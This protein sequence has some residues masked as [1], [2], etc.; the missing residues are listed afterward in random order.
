MSTAPYLSVIT[1]V[2]QAQGYI[3]AFYSKM[4]QSIKKITDDY[5]IIFVNDGSPDLSL[6]KLKA[7]Q[8]NDPRVVIADLSRNFGQ[9][10]A[11]W[12]GLKLSRGEFVFIIDCDME[13]SPDY[14]AEF[15][16]VQKTQAADIVFAAQKKRKRA[17]HHRFTGNVFYWIIAKCTSYPVIPNVLMM[18]LMTRQYVDT[19]L[20]FREYDPRLTIL[21]YNVG[22]KSVCVPIEKQFK[23]AS[24]YTFDKKVEEAWAYL[25]GI[26]N[27]PLLYIAY[28]GALLLAFF[29][30]AALG[31]G[32]FGSNRLTGWLIVML[33]VSTGLVLTAI[34]TV[35]MYLGRV[36]Q[37]VRNPPFP[38][39]QK[40]YGG[41]A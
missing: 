7:I 5:E 16:Q 9:H 29:I 3:D 28:L 4:L 27:R 33:G 11:L 26:S 1:S 15:H 2:Y 19:L 24:S 41:K 40:L 37:E 21:A 6:E 12:A 32:M 35:G 23:G 31:Y 34:G 13:E 20:T 39:I 14:L 17:W 25:I 10:P 18:R 36:L 30:V 8:Q 38:I 22:F